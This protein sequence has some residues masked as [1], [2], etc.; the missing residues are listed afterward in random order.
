MVAR[1]LLLAEHT[2]SRLHLAHLSSARSVD[3]LR[4][5]RERGV[6]VT[7]EVTPHHLFFTENDVDGLDSNLKVNPPLGTREDR[8]ALRWALKDGIID[9]IATDH[10][11]HAPE[12]KEREF[13][14]APSG[15]IGLETAFAACCTALV[16]EEGMEVFTLIDRLTRGPA[17]VLGLE[18]PDYGGGI[19][20]GNR[21]DLVIFD[22]REEVKVD[23]ARFHS[24]S[25][26]CP[27]DGMKLKGRIRWV[28]KDGKVYEC[29]EVDKQRD[30]AMIEEREGGEG[31][32]TW[33]RSHDPGDRQPLFLYRLEDRQ[34]P[35]PAGIR[36]GRR[37]FE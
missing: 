23:A 15:L 25:R 24:L 1:D 27:F 34:G 7:A 19:V 6:R 21:A 9:A 8:Q 35:T 20:E 17:R 11:P 13:D 2:G 26:N 28:L 30:S 37:G 22:P 16:E 36:S 5:A 18:P 14:A 3:L 32:G 12:E 33:G 10:A 31:P 4:T 29:D